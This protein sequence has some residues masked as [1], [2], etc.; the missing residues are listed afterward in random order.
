MSPDPPSQQGKASRRIGDSHPRQKP[1]SKSRSKSSHR[2]AVENDMPSQKPC[3][4]SRSKSSHR[5]MAENDMHMSKKSINK[6]NHLLSYSSVKNSR[7]GISP[8]T[9]QPILF[10]HKSA[11]HEQSNSMPGERQPFYG[12]YGSVPISLAGYTSRDNASSF[13][14]KIGLS[15]QIGQQQYKQPYQYPSNNVPSTSISLAGYTRPTNYSTAAY[16]GLPMGIQTPQ[17]VS[18]Y[19]MRPYSSGQVQYQGQQHHV[20]FANPVSKSRVNQY[21]M[22]P[23]GEFL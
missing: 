22:P 8:E 16:G 4:K 11:P 15:P 9:Q 19:P 3:S 2:M 12:S 14:H 6:P 7:K 21:S 1:R 5:T 10:R 18:Q 17:P 20:A 23:G 13:Q